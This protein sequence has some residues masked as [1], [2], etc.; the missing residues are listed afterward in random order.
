[1]R[2]ARCLRR[3]AVALLVAVSAPVLAQLQASEP[4]LKAAILIN[5]LL[6][7]DWPAN[8]LQSRDRLTICHLSDSAVARALV[9]LDGKVRK[10]QQLQTIRTDGAQ[11]AHCHVV[12]LAP[13]DEAQLPEVVQGLRATRGVLITGDTP[14]YVERGVMINLE[15]AAGRVVFDVNLS[16]ARQ[17]GLNISSKALRLARTVME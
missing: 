9:R 17:A 1:M 11:L 2:R 16:A 4:E 14:G 10:H 7:I 3:L 5:M 15:L 8:S 12:Y 6:F 13:G